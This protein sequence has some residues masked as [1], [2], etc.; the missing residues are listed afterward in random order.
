MLLLESAS[1]NN[2]CLLGGSGGMF[3]QENFD[4]CDS[5][6]FI[7]VISRLKLPIC[8]YYTNACIEMYKIQ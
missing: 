1:C 3:P 6:S 8:Y 2:V 7:L 4:I 5:V